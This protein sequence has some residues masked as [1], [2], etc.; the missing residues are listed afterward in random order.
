MHYPLGWLVIAML[1]STPAVSGTLVLKITGLSSEVEKSV[2]ARLTLAQYLER[3]VSESRVQQLLVSGDAQIREALEPFGYYD[4][5]VTHRLESHDGQFHAEFQVEPGEPVRVTEVRVSVSDD[6]ERIPAVARALGEFVPKTGAPLRHDEYEYSKAAISN[7]LTNAGYL[8][9]RIRD[10]RVAVTAATRTATIDL[11]W[12]CGLRYRFGPARFPST[13]FSDSLLARMVP[14]TE[15]E[16]YSADKLFEFQRRLNN[17][18]YFATTRVL[19]R[20][21]EAQ[22]GRVPVDVEL[23]PAKRDIY[24]GGIYASTDTG[25]GVNVTYQ[26]R[27]LNRSGHKLQAE[28]D[29]AERLQAA[30]LGYRIPFAGANERA[31]TFGVTYRDETT[32][33]TQENTTKLAINETRKWPRYTR[34]LGIQMIGGDFEIGSEHGNSDE[35]YAEAVLTRTVSDD[36][37]FPHEGHSLMSALRVAPANVISR[38]RFAALETRGKWI[39][40]PGARQRVILRGSLAAMGVDDFDELPPELRFFAGGDR[41][42]RGFDY[43]AIGSSND[44]GDVIGGTFLG[45][46]STEYERY[47]DRKWGAAVFVDAGDAF[48]SDDFDWN[49]GAGLGARWKSPVGVVRLD[50]AV[51]VET[52]LK[53]SW[54][55]HLTIGPDL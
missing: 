54:R 18:D 24:G 39:W 44:A 2:R 22:D 27:W 49:I 15:G 53:K 33:S 23:A 38:T 37:A 52:E 1:M 13:G 41:S 46:L 29:Y 48:L 7:A 51:P 40:S 43:E 32:D 8:S 20:I 42:I 30:S 5:T 4:G 10:H 50:V 16:D 21:A 3:D 9:A 55:V 6:A 28:G 45:V 25:A 34:T 17:A 11:S 19:P 47:F 36:P 26:R 12:D 31:L 35:L 14:W